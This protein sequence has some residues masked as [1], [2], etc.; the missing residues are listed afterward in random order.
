[1]QK[2]Q[3]KLELK[4]KK[5][6]NKDYTK[7][8]KAYSKARKEYIQFLKHNNLWSDKLEEKYNPKKDNNKLKMDKFD[9]DFVIRYTRAKLNKQK[10]SLF[11]KKVMYG[12]DK[13]KNYEYCVELIRTIEEVCRVNKWTTKKIWEDKGLDM[14]KYVNKLV[15]ASEGYS[16]ILM[17]YAKQKFAKRQ[18]ENMGR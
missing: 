15:K 11:P 1:M 17:Y 4:Q 14:E 6:A 2:K 10:F 18:A 8:I 5:Q 13:K 16:E 7:A 9:E 3:Q 12:D